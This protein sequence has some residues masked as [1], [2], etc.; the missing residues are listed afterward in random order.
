MKIKNR[1]IYSTIIGSL[2]LSGCFG[3]GGDGGSTNEIIPP[4]P[5]STAFTVNVQVP[6]GLSTTQ[7][8]TASPSFF[9]DFFISEAAAATVSNQLGAGNFK[10]AIVDAAGVVTQ[11]V[12]PESITQEPDGS[13]IVTLAGGARVDCVIIADVSKTPNVTIGQTLPS[14]AIYAPTA[15]EQ[16]NI[17]I[18]STSAYQEFLAA[19]EDNLNLNT[20]S[21]FTT[22]EIAALVV[23]AQGLPLP[24]Y[25]VGQ[26][27]EQ[28]LAVAIPELEA[29]IE[30]EIIVVGNTDTTFSLA[31]YVENGGGINWYYG[32]GTMYERGKVSYDASTQV[33]TDFEEQF[34]GT[35]WVPFTSGSIDG[36]ILTAQGWTPRADEVEVVTLNADGSIKLRDTTANDYQETLSAVKIDIAGRQIRLFVPEF[37]SVIPA[38]AVFSTGAAAHLLSF[39]MPADTYEIWAQEVNSIVTAYARRNATYNPITTLEEM[40]SASA[41]TSTDPQQMNLVRN[42]PISLELIRSATSDTSGTVNIFTI[43]TGTIPNV[44]TVVGTTTWERRTVAGKDI[45][46]IAATGNAIQDEEGDAGFYMLTVYNNTDAGVSAVVEGWF[47]PAGTVSLEQDY[48]FNDIAA[49]DINGSFDPNILTCNYSSP[50][51]YFAGQPA[52]FNSYNDF[53]E[54]LTDCGGALPVVA[55]DIEGSTLMQTYDVNG[56]SIVESVT[57][58]TGGIFTVSITANGVQQGSATGNWAIANNLLTITDPAGGFFTVIASIGNNHQ[59]SYEEQAVWTNTPDA[60]ISDPT[61]IE[62]EISHNFFVLAASPTPPPASSLSCSSESGWNDTLN[63]P[64]APFFSFTDFEA[65]V[66]AC[67]DQNT[68]DVA[69]VTG[70]WVQGNETFVFNSNGTGTWTET[71]NPS[72]PVAW[73]IVNNYVLITAGAGSAFEYWAFTPSGMKAYF[74]ENSFADVIA[75]GNADGELWT[76]TFVKQ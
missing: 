36:L 67:G 54:V 75:D 74:E 14:D 39:S 64:A 40:F 19:V 35:N 56:A 38:S 4:P 49:G 42:G 18:R 8:A 68:I 9:G 27:L 66:D 1:I 59:L 32:D 7:V 37:N 26:T 10:V 31:T 50:W 20:A 60:S 57:Y 44:A 43:D 63:Q 46:L 61:A 41:S 15:S 17:D 71:S 3:G 52:T 21:G 34:D 45:V 2:S 25:T 69:F 53:L 24:T 23:T 29:E 30:R 55:A 51:D 48:T 72:D 73:S 16:F 5:A 6:D 76:P 28:Y 62:G 33:T 22:D 65:V 13:W 70:T 11:I 12:T 58:S 47:T